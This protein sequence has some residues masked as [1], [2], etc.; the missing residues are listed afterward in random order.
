MNSWWHNMDDST[1]DPTQTKG[2]T[3]RLIILPF[4]LGQHD[5]FS[6]IHEVGQASKIRE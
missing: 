1:V 3:L 4:H 2:S 6:V 5:S